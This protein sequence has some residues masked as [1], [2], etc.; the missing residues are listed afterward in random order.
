MGVEVLAE[1]G[2]SLRDVLFEQGV[3]FPCGGQGRCRG[4]K[5]LVH[6]GNFPINDVQRDRLTESELA[7]GWRL[8]C[9]G[10]VNDDLVIELHQWDAAVL[11]NDSDFAF[12]PQ[13]GYGV[14]VDIGTT[15]IV[16]QLLNLQTGRVLAVRTALNVQARHG[17]DVMSRVQFSTA[18]GQQKVLETA[19]R[20]QVGSLIRQ[21]VKKTE[22]DADNLQ[23]V[24]AVGNTVM[25]HLFCGID[26]EPLSH[27]PF[28]P[29]D[30][31]LQTLTATQLGWGFAPN[32]TVYFLP[33]L[34]GFVG[35]DVL[36]GIL[37]TGVHT[38]SDLVGLIDLGTNGEM[39]FGSG[40]NLICASTAA[41]PAFE[42]AM[43]SCGMR[44]SSGA[45]WRVSNNGSG[46]HT[47]VLGDD[48]A[49]GVCG[50]GLVDAV[51]VGLDIEQVG[52]SGRLAKGLDGLKLAENITLTQADIRH[53]QLAKGAIAAGVHIILK[54][55]GTRASEVRKVYLAGAF[56]NYVNHDSARRIGLIEF[57]EKRLQASG[58]AAL[59]GAKLALFT[60]GAPDYS[61]VVQNIEHITLSSDPEFQDTYVD[62]M[63]FPA[64]ED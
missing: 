63:S 52:P 12:T 36:A 35:S 27:V 40:G 20:D 5:I 2:A 57:D 32:A 6:A 8:G 45:I 39:V 55:L 24:V 62:E 13:E 31:G 22:I 10:F 56:G 14:A 4:C 44:A 26:V 17:A 15:T 41:G 11:S 23:K 64:D 43:I 18:D 28:E 34:G 49:R 58:N 29:I 50:S 61:A 3:E 21:L 19:I 25:H 7:A 9:Q 33:C 60:Q 30:D 38:S 59:L 37:A 47:E 51:A 48:E 53:L 54:K 46:F 42:G 1:P 16:A